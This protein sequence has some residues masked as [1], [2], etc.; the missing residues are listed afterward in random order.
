MRDKVSA[1][2][3][4]KDVFME[5]FKA[6][7]LVLF[8]VAFIAIYQNC[9][10]FAS[11]DLASTLEGGP[12]PTISSSIAGPTTVTPIPIQ[13]N[14][15]RE[16][17]G[18]SIAAVQVTRG[19]ASNFRVVQDGRNFT[20]DV[21]PSDWGDVIV[22]I[23]P[24]A[25]KDTIGKES[26]PSNT[27]SIVFGTSNGN[28]FLV[29]IV[30]ERK[31][32]FYFNKT[33]AG[34][35]FGTPCA[36]TAQSNERD[37]TCILDIPEGDVYFH[38]F[39]F[40]FQSP[41][42]MCRYIERTNYSYYNYETGIGPK[43]ISVFVNENNEPHPGCGATNAARCASIDGGPIVTEAIMLNPP[44]DL[45]IVGVTGANPLCRYDYT[46]VG[47]PN[48]CLGNYRLSKSVIPKRVNVGDPTPAA[49]ISGPLDLN[50]GGSFK[51][52]LG[53]P[54]ADDAMWPKTSDGFPI[55]LIES[56]ANGVNAKYK[57]QKPIDLYDYYSIS[58][59]NYYT[60]SA[61]DR[62]SLFPGIVSRA[63][64]AI[65]PIT[66]RRLSSNDQR[67]YATGVNGTGERLPATSGFYV[68]T[69]LDQAW[70]IKHRIRVQV[71]EWNTYSDFFSFGQTP[72]GI[73]GSPD[74]TGTE[75]VNCNMEFSSGDGCNDLL[76][77]DDVTAGG[78]AQPRAN[79]F[80]AAL[81]K[82]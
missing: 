65:D 61:T 33:G 47:G 5:R 52:C 29:D 8:S 43:N 40:N 70:E 16:V 75:G 36:I 57:I 35:P 3:H 23:P 71:R 80:P 37:V 44:A 58:A 9:G 59:A 68:F 7:Y 34:I 14:F 49:V 22:Y 32:P 79:F 12:V 15:N 82:R 81:R 6:Y 18:M 69:C 20:F 64:L 28:R 13:V 67:F 72:A 53:G 50:W 21:T 41:P 38:G 24:R 27:F 51:G 56:A 76:D 48:C 60:P 66:D 42:G 4:G 25:V 1:S 10:N 11:N 17:V 55:N 77:W 45:E 73:N 26:M 62:T 74:V 78:A 31:F 2:K 30:D 19:V 46:G 39:E 54:G 63:P